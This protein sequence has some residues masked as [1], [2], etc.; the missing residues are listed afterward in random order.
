[1]RTLVMLSLLCWLGVGGNS[2]FEG[3]PCALRTC[4]HCLS[5]VQKKPYVRK[6][7]VIQPEISPLQAPMVP[8]IRRKRTCALFP[9]A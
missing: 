9:K 3:H 6:I 5:Y 1:M 8:T 7:P 4:A 2:A